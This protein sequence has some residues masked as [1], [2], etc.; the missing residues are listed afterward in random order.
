MPPTAGHLCHHPVA[1]H[2]FP[3]S[4]TLLGDFSFSR[5]SR[6]ERQAQSLTREGEEA[7]AQVGR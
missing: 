7:V 4:E 2:S 5:D 3:V 6:E 1:S